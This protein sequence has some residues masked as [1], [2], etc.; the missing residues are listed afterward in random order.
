MPY[1][2]PDQVRD[3]LG[4]TEDDLS[5][6]VLTVPIRRASKDIDAAC[7]GWGVYADT[8]LKFEST[9]EDV[10]LSDAQLAH[11]AEATSAQVE[12]RMTMGDDFMVKEQYESQSG[13]SYGTAGKL[14]KVCGEA[15]TL[16]GQAGLLRL[17]GKASNYAAD[18]Y[19]EL[20]RIN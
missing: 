11:L 2:T 12:Y 20:P 10:N 4:V 7:G 9:D 3:F 16:L 14:R 6:D 18:R 8:G 15:Y 5:D 1:A 19:G 13:P 17:H